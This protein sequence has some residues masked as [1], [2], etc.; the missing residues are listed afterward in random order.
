MPQQRNRIAAEMMLAAAKVVHEQ[1]SL[2]QDHEWATGQWHVDWQAIPTAFIVAEAVMMGLAPRIGH[3]AAHDLE[4]AA[5]AAPWRA[6]LAPVIRP[7]PFSSRLQRQAGGHQL[8]KRHTLGRV[9]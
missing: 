4:R 1:Y 9:E 6:S 2:V 7:A 8:R 5:G 3:Q